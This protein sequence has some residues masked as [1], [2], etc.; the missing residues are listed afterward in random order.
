MIWFPK[1]TQ[2]GKV[3]TLLL[4]SPVW[5]LRTLSLQCLDFIDRKRYQIISRIYER[6]E[7]SEIYTMTEKK[8]I[9]AKERCGCLKGKYHVYFDISLLTLLMKPKIRFSY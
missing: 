9:R 8:T 6:S 4:H 3:L 7:D 5:I 1:L 2:I